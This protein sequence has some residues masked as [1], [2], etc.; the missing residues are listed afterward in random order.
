MAQKASS[1]GSIDSPGKVCQNDQLKKR[2]HIKA[3][4]TTYPTDMHE[5][6]QQSFLTSQIT[7]FLSQL[8]IFLITVSSISGLSH[9]LTSMYRSSSG[10]ANTNTTKAY[11]PHDDN[12]TISLS[13]L[14]GS[15][16]FL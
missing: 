3:K 15:N 1:S 14:K 8:S 10:P 4:N 9:G 7:F 12:L 13:F 16:T 6:I 5:D 2:F 11:L